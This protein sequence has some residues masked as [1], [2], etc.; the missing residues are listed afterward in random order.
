MVICNI[1]NQSALYLIW[2]LTEEMS[3]GGTNLPQAHD[4]F[5]H[6]N[7]YSILGKTFINSTFYE[8]LI[9]SILCHFRDGIYIL[10]KCN[11]CWVLVGLQ[12][13]ISATQ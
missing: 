8:P 7:S 11:I 12:I 10:A 4:K 5:Y 13:K 1:K 2:D 9:H 3:S 6:E